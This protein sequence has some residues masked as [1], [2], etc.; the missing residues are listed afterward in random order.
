MPVRARVRS[1]AKRR[2]DALSRIITDSNPKLP[3]LTQSHH[4]FSIERCVRLD[5]KLGFGFA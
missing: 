5:T 2:F 3:K 1:L 4:T